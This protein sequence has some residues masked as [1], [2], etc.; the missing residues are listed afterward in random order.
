MYLRG[1]LP[2][3]TSLAGVS[4]ID[5]FGICIATPGQR[6]SESHTP[7]ISGAEASSAG[8]A[9]AAQAAKRSAAQ[10]S[11]LEAGLKAEM[12]R[13]LQA[14]S[15]AA[16]YFTK[17]EA[18][19]KPIAAGSE[20]AA[21]ITALAEAHRSTGQ[22]VNFELLQN[23]ESRPPLSSPSSNGKRA[24]GLTSPRPGANGTCDGVSAQMAANGAA[25]VPGALAPHS[26]PARLLPDIPSAFELRAQSICISGLNLPELLPDVAAAPG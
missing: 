9:S 22:L 10:L 14:D 26:L 3:G 13:L 18:K 5:T 6:D 8:N 21:A 16:S 12:E 15:A 20:A 17:V 1:S 2:R 19:L 11:S 4:D 7:K 23:F 24:E 25:D